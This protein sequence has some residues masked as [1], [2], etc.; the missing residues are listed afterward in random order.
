MLTKQQE[1]GIAI[2][3]LVFLHMISQ[4]FLKDMFRKRIL[5]LAIIIMAIVLMFEPYTSK[6]D[7]FSQRIKR[8]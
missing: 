8:I 4:N 1:I 7:S 2:L 3:I 6:Q 5:V